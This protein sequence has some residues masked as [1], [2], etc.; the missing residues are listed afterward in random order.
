MLSQ[1]NVQDEGCD[2]H[3]RGEAS[4]NEA[5]GDEGHQ[6]TSQDNAQKG[7][8]CPEWCLNKW[9]AREA[10]DRRTLW[11]CTT[12]MSRSHLGCIEG[13]KG[14]VLEGTVCWGHV[15]KLLMA[16]LRVHWWGHVSV[17]GAQ[18]SPHLLAMCHVS[19]A[20]HHA[21]SLLNMRA[22]STSSC[23]SNTFSTGFSTHASVLLSA[24]SSPK[25]T[26]SMPILAL[27]E[28]QHIL[29]AH[30]IL[31]RNPNATPCITAITGWGMRT[32]PVMIF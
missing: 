9:Q 2:R 5:K 1:N 28:A 10:R 31:S 25:F 14:S 22:D 30:I 3:K 19:T 32:S 11:G 18:R 12:G 20:K 17:K 27:E 21:S 29:T 16:L 7:V 8:A 4:H 15:Y 24:A 6:V 23:N 13:I 26:S